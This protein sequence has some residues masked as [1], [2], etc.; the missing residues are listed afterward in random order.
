MRLSPRSWTAA[1]AQLGLRRVGSARQ[2]SAPCQGRIAPPRRNYRPA[3]ESLETR[4]LLAA[5]PLDDL[6]AG[7][8]PAIVVSADVNTLIAPTLAPPSSVGVGSG[9]ST[10]SISSPSFHLDF[11]A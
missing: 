7:V 4:A 1:L 6:E 10:R 5:A 8:S 11:P 9:A 3:V 2:N